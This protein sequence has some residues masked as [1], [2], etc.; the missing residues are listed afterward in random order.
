MW[1]V[2]RASCERLAPLGG[3]AKPLGGL[4]ST[5][6][7]YNE[8]SLDHPLPL[9]SQSGR[10]R[11]AGGRGTRVSVGGGSSWGLA[12]PQSL[13]RQTT[14]SSGVN[15]SDAPLSPTS[16]EAFDSPAT[17]HG[18]GPWYCLW[19]T[20]LPWVGQPGGR[21][22]HSVHTLTLP[23]QWHWGAL[24]SL[25]PLSDLVACP[26]LLLCQRRFGEW[27]AGDV[28]WAAL[29]GRSGRGD[30]DAGWPPVRAVLLW[31]RGRGLP[32]WGTSQCS[33]RSR[34]TPLPV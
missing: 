5:G 17:C 9:Q 3:V 29:T 2:T 27:V 13:A 6:D 19:G 22:W 33:A 34:P 26:P 12:C 14:L 8:A 21:P 4:L 11:L 7:S 31:V 16:Q 28:C 10:P 30:V 18:A 20:F 24:G 32:E 1:L 15:G 25:S 23:P